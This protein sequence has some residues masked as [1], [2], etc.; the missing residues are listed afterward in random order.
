[1]TFA[2]LGMTPPQKWQCISVMVQP[3]MVTKAVV[4]KL[5]E[6]RQRRPRW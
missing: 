4:V 3:P 2:P 6:M 5:G 1:L